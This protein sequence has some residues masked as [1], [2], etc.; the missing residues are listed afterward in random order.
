MNGF[1]TTVA[2]ADTALPD[3]SKHVKFNYGMVLGVDDFTQEFAYLSARDQWIARDLIG[4][5]TVSGLRVSVQPSGDGPRVVVDAG[6][7]VT[8][9]GQLVRVPL[10]QCASVND[11]LLGDAQIAWLQQQAATADRADVYVTLCYRTCDTDTVPIP[12]EPCRDQSELTAASRVVDDFRLELRFAPPDQRDETEVRDFIDWLSAIP[13]VDGPSS[14]TI[15]QFAQVVR[16]AA[17]LW[18]SPPASPIDFMFG[19]PPTNVRIGRADVLR[20]LRTAFRIWATEL[21]PRW[22]AAWFAAQARCSDQP[23]AQIPAPEQCLL[24]ARLDTA[25]VR[26]SRPQGTIW[27]AASPIDIRIDEEAR[28]I[29]VPLR[30][31]QEE[32]WASASAAG[33]AGVAG[34]LIVAAGAVVIGTPSAGPYQLRGFVPVPPPPNPPP[35]G[36]FKIGFNGYTNPSGAAFDYVVVAT[37]KPGAFANPRVEFVAF[38]NDGIRLR[39]KDNTTAI[40]NTSIN[41]NAVMVLVTRVDR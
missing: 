17:R 35:P 6:V 19:S 37:P 25:I 22:N 14:L 39:L 34:S 31:L 10:A 4:Y 15:D 12:G 23:P 13:V 30:L 5:G 18:D 32:V 29:L 8:P 36:E 21:R 1:S 28:P 20:F 27:R 3:P 7:A 33:T 38:E 41:G 11:W 2:T 40:P 26:V 9:R 24:L 16:D